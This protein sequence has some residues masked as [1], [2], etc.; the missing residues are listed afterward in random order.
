MAFVGGQI[1]SVKQVLDYNT[2]AMEHKE[3]AQCW[4][5]ASLLTTG[6]KQFSSLVKQMRD[7]EPALGAME[8]LYGLDAD[9]L[10]AKWRTF[11]LGQR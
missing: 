9:Q 3:Y 8:K 1:A 2:D 4:S 11:A 5:L 7:G 6:A 10:L